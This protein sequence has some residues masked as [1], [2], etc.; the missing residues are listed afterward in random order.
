MDS[1]QK[2]SQN[3]VLAEEPPNLSVT[4]FRDP[5]LA[6]YPS[7]ATLLGHPSDTLYGTISG[8]LH[9]DGPRLFLYRV[10]P[11]ALRQ[12]EYLHPLVEDVPGNLRPSG[13]WGGDLGVN[14]ECANFVSLSSDDGTE[15]RDAIILGSEGG[16][17]RPHVLDFYVQNAA[18][19]R[20]TVRYA[21]W[22]FHT[23]HAQPGGQVRARLGKAGVFDWG[24][25]YAV[26]TSRHPD[27]RTVAWGWATEEDLPQSRLDTKGWNGCFGV[28]REV[29]LAVVDGVQGLVGGG[30]GE[31]D[32]E[33]H[34][35]IKDG[36]A[37]TLGLRPLGELERL[38]RDVV[39][40]ADGVQVDGHLFGAPTAVRIELA[41]SF[42]SAPTADVTLH[43]RESADRSTRTSIVY[44]PL[45]QTLRV[46]RARSNTHADILKS[47]EIGAF[48][49]FTLA[50]GSIET[51]RL[52][53]LL[54]EDLIEVFAN[55]RFGLTTRTYS[56]PDARG[57]SIEGVSQ[58]VSASI[59][60]WEVADIGLNSQVP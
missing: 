23:L 13:K 12:W 57:V 46:V 48:A 51:L 53:V 11:S 10:Q 43:V 41:V 28:P 19:P 44:S 49:L 35:E 56:G 50:D 4:G 20:R 33:G 8:G 37:V 54:D 59:S 27:G 7:L 24:L 42:G 9:P 38:K 14:W 30:G 34:W 3:P 39:F 29:Y 55:D 40:Q 18:S 25:L 26:A 15:R 32:R 52:I 5:F 6:P 47:D 22:F 16:H 45:G 21:N 17:E 2:D 31:V 1:G 58:G 36:R 60:A